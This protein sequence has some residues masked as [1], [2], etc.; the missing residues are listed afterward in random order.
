MHICIYLAESME[1]NVSM[2]DI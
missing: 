2:F 1:R